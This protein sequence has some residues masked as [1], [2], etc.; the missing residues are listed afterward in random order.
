MCKVE[1]NDSREFLEFGGVN[2]FDHFWSLNSVWAL[3]VV[4][5]VSCCNGICSKSAMNL[6]M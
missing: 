1:V 5:C 3:C 4:T 2:L 6:V